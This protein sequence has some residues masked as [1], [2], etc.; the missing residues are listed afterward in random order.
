MSMTIPELSKVD[1]S[2]AVE[3]AVLN[4]WDSIDPRN[5]SMFQFQTYTKW[6]TKKLH[7]LLGPGEEGEAT[8]LTELK[9]GK[10]VE[11]HDADME[12]ARAF[13]EEEFGTTTRVDLPEA[14]K[15]ARPDYGAR[16]KGAIEMGEF[17]APSDYGPRGKFDTGIR[18]ATKDP[19]SGRF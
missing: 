4:G 15:G 12:E 7:G 1:L 11:E 8:E 2:K 5:W 19:T 17:H 9:K 14:S 3:F 6:V 10:P 13:A 18:P 16:E